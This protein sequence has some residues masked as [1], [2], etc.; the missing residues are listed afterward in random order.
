MMKETLDEAAA[1]WVWETNGHK[2]SN[3]DDTAGDNYGSF[4]AGAEWQREQME[5][6]RDWETWKAWKNGDTI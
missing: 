4:K 3:S 1:C 2:W 5:S 6:L